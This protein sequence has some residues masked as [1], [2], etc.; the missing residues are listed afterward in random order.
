MDT[1]SKEKRSETMRAVK[2]KD[3]KME[4][5]FRKL[6]WK[7]GVRYRKN[8]SGLTGKP[9]I[10]FKGKK[11]VVF[12]DS[13]F[14]HGCKQHCRL[15]ASNRE[16]WLAKIKANRERDGVV[17]KKYEDMGWSIFRFWEHD[18]KHFPEKAVTK[19][20]LALRNNL[21]DSKGRRS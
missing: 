4:I 6:L 12:L 13:C 5:A 19:I 14:W 9:D 21:S 10:A 11:L 7:S 2:G 8:V 20:V 1:V 17:R 16:Y 15:P 3:T 18:L